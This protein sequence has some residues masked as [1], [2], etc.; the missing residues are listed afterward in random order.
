MSCGVGHRCGSDPVLSCVVVAIAQAVSY[1]SLAWECPY[2]MGAAL[3]KKKKKK[4][5]ILNK[6]IIVLTFTIKEI[7]SS[8][9]ALPRKPSG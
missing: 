9:P 5:Q 1:S 4:I 7:V 8:F 3:K 2:A 6:L